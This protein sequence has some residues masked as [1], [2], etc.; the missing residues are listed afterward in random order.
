MMRVY[1]AIVK[2]VLTSLSLMVVS[3]VSADVYIQCPGDLDGDGVIDNTGDPFHQEHPNAVCRSITGGDGYI[4]MADTT[5]TG[6]TRGRQLYMFGFSDVTGVAPADVIETATTGATFPGPKIEV[7]EGDELFLSLTNVGMAGRPDLDDPHTVHWHGYPDAAP[8]FDG[9]PDVS[10]SIHMGGTLTYY[11]NANNPGTYMYHC[12]VEA[13]EHMQM[14]MLGSLY[15]TAAQDNLQDGTDLNGFTHH[16][17]YS[18][19]YNDGDGSTYY[20]VDYPLQLA[21]FDP[22]F[23]DAS[24]STQPLP[25]ALMNDTYPLLNGRGYPD[26]LIPG[27]LANTA[28]GVLSQPEDALISAFQGDKVL[29]RLSNLSITQFFTIISP[30]AP[31]KIVGTGAHQLVGTNGADLSYMTNSVT[32]GGG[33]AFDAIIDTAGLDPGTYFIYTSNLNNL[34]NNTEARGGIMTEIRILDPVLADLAL[35]SDP[36]EAANVQLSPNLALA[37]A[38]A[39]LAEQGVVTGSN[40][41]WLAERNLKLAERDRLFSDRDQLLNP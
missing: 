17:G 6:G 36:D 41:D 25:F 9:L 40:A 38:R 23:H 8:I 30:Q 15:V 3:G 10:I 26:T 13:T 7:A 28:N 22:E 20:D 33:Q 32:M 16:D 21:S 18:Y 5:V 11:Y 2:L 14:G 1:G 12:H 27:P 35:A 31:M 19:A 34:S 39:A 29:L 4:N 24:E 37:A